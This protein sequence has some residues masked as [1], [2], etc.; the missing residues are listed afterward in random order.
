MEKTMRA[1]IV[2]CVVLGAVGAVV[3]LLLGAFLGGNWATGFQL[4]HLRGYEAMGVV[5]LILGGALGVLI[6]AY[7]AWR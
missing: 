6:G 7:S 5:G 1:G 4:F 3:G 2:K